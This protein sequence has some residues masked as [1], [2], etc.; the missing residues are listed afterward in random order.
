[1]ADAVGGSGSGVATELCAW[2]SKIVKHGDVLSKVS[3]GI[4]W[5]CTEIYFPAQLAAIRAKCDH[6]FEVLEIEHDTDAQPTGYNYATETIT[7]TVYRIH[8]KTEECTLCG[9]KQTGDFEDCDCDDE[10]D[11]DDREDDD[12]DEDRF[13]E[14]EVD[15][16]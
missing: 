13:D 16:G 9:M 15:L 12:R 11:Y 3:H 14:S 10:P 1:M 6:E 8:A 4:C 2:C 7:E 5:K